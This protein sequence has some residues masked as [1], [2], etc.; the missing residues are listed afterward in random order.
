MNRRHHP[1]LLVLA[2]LVMLA[3]GCTVAPEEKILRDFFRAS[4]LRDTTGLGSFAIVSFDPR[5]DGQV[6]S[7]EVLNIGEER[8]SG[9]SIREYT[10]AVEAAQ[11]A[12]KAFSKEKMAYQNANLKAIERVV[13]AESRKQP[14]T[15]QD[16]AVQSAWAKWRE[17]AASHSRNVSEA[18]RKLS[19]VRGFVELSLSTPNGPTPDV[20]RLE[21]DI[22]EKDITVRAD[23][24]DEQG[25]T[26]EKT[27][28]VTLARAVMREG[29]GEPQAG[30]WIVRLVRTA[31]EPPTT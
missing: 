3:T 4:R 22:V 16:T 1:S 2:S 7:F 25:E 9:L 15:R 18:R 6:Q 28:V 17:D 11:E 12:E 14:V 24:R 31:G 5:T 30:R 20:S 10:E 26:A 29:S 23:V 8:R 21:G 27:L 19:G 13:R